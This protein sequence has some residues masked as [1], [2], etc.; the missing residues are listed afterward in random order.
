MTCEGPERTGTFGPSVC[1]S[2]RWMPTMLGTDS[3]LHFSFAVRL[4]CSDQYT[5][6]QRTRSSIR[7]PCSSRVPLPL[8]ARH[9]SSFTTI[10]S[11]LAYLCAACVSIMFLT[12]LHHVEKGCVVIVCVIRRIFWIVRSRSS[13]RPSRILTNACKHMGDRTCYAIAEYD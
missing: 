13:Y 6:L 8:R 7:N 2:E 12:P 4:F 10:F 9:S 1:I 11:P 3:F 5:V